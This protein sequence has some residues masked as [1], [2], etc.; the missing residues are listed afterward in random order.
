[1]LA[2]VK[3]IRKWQPYLLGKPFIIWTDQKIL[4]FLLEQRITIPTQ[5]RWL[6]KILEYDYVIKYKKGIENQ[7]ADAL[8][9]MATLEL[10]TISILVVS[11]WTVL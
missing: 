10:L 4:K 1:M 3:A 6:L 9:R 2:V 11:W 5:T 8:S 7:G